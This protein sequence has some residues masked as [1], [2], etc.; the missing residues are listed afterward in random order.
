MLGLP[1]CT[2]E[3]GLESYAQACQRLAESV[4]ITLNLQAQGITPQQF[5]QD[6]HLVAM[7]AYEDQCTPCN[8]RL[9]LVS[10][11]QAILEKAYTGSK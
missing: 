10:D 2:P 6:S 7:L 11:L 4:G 3:D 1:A 9:P 5:T 8:P